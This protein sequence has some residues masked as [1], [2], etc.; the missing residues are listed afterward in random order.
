MSRSETKS[1]GRRVKPEPSAGSGTSL[2]GKGSAGD[3]QNKLLEQT[4]RHVAIREA[5]R[6]AI[7]RELHDKFGQYLTVMELELDAI[8]KANDVTPALRDRLHKLKALTLSAH[9]DMNNLACEIRPIPLQG[10]SL[11]GACERLAQ[12]WSERS[13]LLFDL[14]LSLGAHALESSIA[15]TIYRV[16]QEAVINVA[17]HANATRIGI[18]LRASRDEVVLVVED[19]GKGFGWQMNVDRAPSPQLGIRGM[20]E[21]LELVGGTLEIETAR[22]RGTT[23]LVRV[24]L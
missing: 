20:K 12:D 17:K 16:L 14:H 11:S 18:I 23:L 15:D 21:R 5:E 22:D 19:D 3:T 9:G 6:A 2:R 10:Q 13:A 24:P 7:A 8:G 4:R 1:I